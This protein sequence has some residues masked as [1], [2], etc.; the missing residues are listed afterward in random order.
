VISK[1]LVNEKKYNGGNWRQTTEEDY[2]K[3]FKRVA[4][5]VVEQMVYCRLALKKR[6]E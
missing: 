3:V 4:R 5:K 6:I 2:L 1:G